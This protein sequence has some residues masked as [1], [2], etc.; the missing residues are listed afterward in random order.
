ML[1]LSQEI[2]CRDDILVLRSPNPGE[3]PR[4]LR[5]FQELLHQS[6]EFMNYP[7]HYYDQR[8]S[9]EQEKFISVFAEAENSFAICVYQSDEII[10]HLVLKNFAY[11]CGAHAAYLVMGILKQ[12][13]GNG[14]GTSL[15][16]LAQDQSSLC[17]ITH[18][19]LRVRSYN[20]PAIALY[21][22]CQFH[23]I[24]EMKNAAI[25]NGN[26]ESEYL[27]AWDR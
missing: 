7:S 11:P 12:Y 6:S 14:I 26:S 5:Y 18:I 27:Y 22:K 21:E 3:G 19:E 2:T 8:T 17:G 24:G 4:L 9:E 1:I 25:L 10:G 23:R 16:K 13:H 20:Q 15:I